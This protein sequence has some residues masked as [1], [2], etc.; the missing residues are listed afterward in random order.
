MTE[1]GDTPVAV[2]KEKQEKITGFDTQAHEASD[3]TAFGVCLSL[4]RADFVD[5]SHIKG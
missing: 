1:S 5:V 4:N 3:S 2:Q